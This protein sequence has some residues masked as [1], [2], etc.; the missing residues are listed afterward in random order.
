MTTPDLTV[1]GH[2]IRQPIRRLEA[3]GVPIGVT[4]VSF[5]CAE[6]VATC[7]VTGQPDLY[8]V[9]IVIYADGRTLESKSLKLY[10]WSF[11]DEGIFAEHLAEQIARDVSEC[12]AAPVRVFLAQSVRGGIVITTT[13][14]SLQP[15]SGV[16]YD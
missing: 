11:K 13:A 5:R 15:P 16:R 10:L 6:L 1:L 4:E 7:P 9:E 12:V 2:E 14:D 3:I 8:D